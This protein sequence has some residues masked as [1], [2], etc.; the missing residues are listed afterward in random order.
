MEIR[1]C[2]GE[3]LSEKDFLI[4]DHCMVFLFLRLKSLD[5]IL[6]WLELTLELLRLDLWCEGDGVSKLESEGFI[7]AVIIVLVTVPKKP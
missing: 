6:R 2:G 3:I 5:L 1:G 4:G 7:I